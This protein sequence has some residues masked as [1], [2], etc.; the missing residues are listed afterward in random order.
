[1]PHLE[2]MGNSFIRAQTLQMLVKDVHRTCCDLPS[3][4][5]MFKELIEPASETWKLKTGQVISS[6]RL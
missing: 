3:H 2:L 4:G 5:A 1:M 6:P